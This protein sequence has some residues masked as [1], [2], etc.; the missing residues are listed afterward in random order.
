[1]PCDY[2]RRLLEEVMGT[3]RHAELGIIQDQRDIQRAWRQDVDIS[4]GNARQ[5]DRPRQTVEG[6]AHERLPL[7][8]AMGIRGIDY[9]QA[10]L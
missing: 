4:R 3:T 6:V 5:H 10:V 1:M 7:V 2:E 8:Q 9:N